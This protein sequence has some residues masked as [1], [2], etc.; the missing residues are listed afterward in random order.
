MNW[1]RKMLGR[2]PGERERKAVE[3][4]KLGARSEVVHERLERALAERTRVIA[5][6]RGTVKALRAGERR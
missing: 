6:T 4:E 2:D 5:A 1:L 3:L